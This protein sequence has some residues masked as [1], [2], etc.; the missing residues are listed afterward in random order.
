MKLWSIQTELAWERLRNVGYL[1]TDLAFV[2]VYFA[3]AYRWLAEQMQERLGPPPS[4]VEFPVWAWAQY[5]GVKKPRPDLR[6][7]GHLPRGQ[8]GILLECDCPAQDVLLS[9]F[10]T[11]H[12]V[13][14]N[15]YLPTDQEDEL[16][17]EAKWGEIVTKDATCA[18]LKQASWQRVLDLDWCDPAGEY[19]SPRHAKI[20]Q[21]TLWELRLSQV[22]SARRFV[23]R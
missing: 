14:N 3:D 11:W 7:A 4:G 2:D 15:W 19:T 20:I 16:A 8:I 22:Q 18:P 21:A 10:L 12:F 17:F 6:Q 5:D 23:A 1:R 13:L 9:D